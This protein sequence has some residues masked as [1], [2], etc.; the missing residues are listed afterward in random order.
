MECLELLPAHTDSKRR[1]GARTETRWFP[2]FPTQNVALQFST[3]TIVSRSRG[4][5]SHTHAHNTRSQ[6]EASPPDHASGCCNAGERTTRARARAWACAY[7][8]RG[9]SS[10]LL[11]PQYRLPPTAAS[12]HRVRGSLQDK[13]ARSTH[14]H[15]HTRTCN[16]PSPRFLSH[17]LSPARTLAYTQRRSHARKRRTEQTHNAPKPLL[18]LSHAWFSHALLS[19]QLSMMR[20]HLVRVRLYA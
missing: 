9:V 18:R 13:T 3:K 4:D 12:R 14:A 17:S 1:R 15:T 20:A 2:P 10:G 7:G 8:A 19:S 16:N 5:R 6:Q 11:S